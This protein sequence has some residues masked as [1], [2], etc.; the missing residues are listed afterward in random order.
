MNFVAKF[1]GRALS[2]YELANLRNFHTKQRN[3]EIDRRIGTKATVRRLNKELRS[4]LVSR[5]VVILKGGWPTVFALEGACRH[6]VRSYLCTEGWGWHEADRNADDI[7]SN[8]LNRL[9]AKRPSWSQGQP[10]YRGEEF[11][12]NVRRCANPKCRSILHEEQK[13]YCSDHCRT[14]VNHTRWIEQNREYDAARKAVWQAKRKAA[15]PEAALA[16]RR[17]RYRR[18]QENRPVA[19]CIRC[20]AIYRS[21]PTQKYCSRRCYQDSKPPQQKERACVVCFGRFYVR[22]QSEP[23]QTCSRKCGQ[24]LAKYGPSK[25]AS[26]N[27]FKCEPVSVE[28]NQ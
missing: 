25:P 21:T 8:A 23:Q 19:E 9:G 10:E 12:G 22:W 17:E 13:R 4:E 14:F 1:T 6:S 18:E 15:D 3:K 24:L 11:H 5:V 2:K 28:K 16:R 26:S 27:N 20:G 7:V